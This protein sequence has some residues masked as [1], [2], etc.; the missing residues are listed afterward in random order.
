VVESIRVQRDH[1]LMPIDFDELAELGVTG[2]LRPRVAEILSV[3]EDACGALL[4]DEYARLCTVLVARLSRK[5]PS[6]LARGDT[7][8][9]LFDRSQQPHVSADQLAAQ[10]GVAKTT[11]ANKAAL[12]LKA[13]EVGVF[14]PELTRHSMLERHPLAW[15]VELNG[16]PIDARALPAEVQEEARRRGLI[17][18]VEDRRAA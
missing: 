14:K 10:L 11:M 18:D 7:R 4:D 9:F 15:L 2:E 1:P 6:P 16:V 12:I 13:L 17:P 5:R 8:N 3:T